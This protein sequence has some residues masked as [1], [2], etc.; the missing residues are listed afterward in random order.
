MFDIFYIGINKQLSSLLPFATQIEDT[1]EIKAKTKMYWV[2]DPNIE[3]TDTDI[4]DF[5]P[6]TYD[7]NYTHIWKWDKQ[8]STYEWQP[9]KCIRMKKGHIWLPGQWTRIAK[10]WMWTPGQWRKI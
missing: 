5:R 1:S 8:N 9:G 4:F 10:G 7:M 3:I 6:E 2:V